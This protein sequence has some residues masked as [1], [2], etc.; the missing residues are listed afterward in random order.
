MLAAADAVKPAATPKAALEPMQFVVG[1][2]K[3]VGQLQRSSAAGAWREKAS[4]V[5][6]FEE[7]KVALV[8]LLED[9]KYFSQM[10]VIP[11]KQSGELV[12][13]ATPKTSTSESPVEDV[14]YR[15]G[16]DKDARAVFTT[17]QVSVDLPAR[18][19]LRVV[20]S[21]DRLLLLYEKQASATL[22]TR[23]AEIGYTR[24]G[25]GFGQG[26]GG[27]E[28]IITGG[29]GTIAVMHEGQTYYVCCTGCRDYFNDNPAKAIADYKQRK[30]DEKA[31]REKQK[32]P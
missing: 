31:E 8:G 16:L 10:R 12:L 27:R 30:A 6:R 20:A 4:W 7:G 17:E 29:L 9:G 22:F 19:S 21:G 23:L 18:I 28:C 2:W 26:G 1:E 11:G 32:A 24:V 5:W 15:G 13:L 3:G 25:S 14:V